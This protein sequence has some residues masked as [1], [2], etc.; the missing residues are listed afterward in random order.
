[1]YSRYQVAKKYLHYYLSASSSVG[2]GIHSP[3]AFDF[4]KN[5]LNDRR[6]FY[7]YEKIEQQRQILLENKSLIEIEDFGAGSAMLKAKQRSVAETVKS[8][9]KSGKFG[10][11]LFRIA[12]YYQPRTM[13]ELG[14]SV[15]L[16]AAYLA[17]AVPNAKLITIEGSPSIAKIAK[18]DFTLLGLTNVQLKIGN[19]DNL[20]PD[21]LNCVTTIDLAF[22]DGNH[23]KDPTLNYFN[24]ISQHIA[25]FS[26]LIF[27]DIHWSKKMEEAWFEIKNTNHVVLT[28]DLFYMGIV[29][30]KNNFKAKQ[31]F[32]IRF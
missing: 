1:M 22:I 4:I 29:F 14:T 21:I 27:D 20:L 32:T 12:N 30:F 19:F 16:S 6:H 5:V 13:I 17:S 28:I 11:L 7:A 26:I 3:F 18:N 2:H 9:S 8:A 15:G 31:H 25:D 10:K 23:R 24:I